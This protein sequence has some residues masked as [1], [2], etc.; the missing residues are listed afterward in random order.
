M[1]EHGAPLAGTYDSRAFRP[2]L[3]G[4]LVPP[5]TTDIIDPNLKDA[6]GYRSATAA[7][8]RTGCA[9]MCSPQPA[10]LALGLTPWF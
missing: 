2:V 10:S 7:T 8:T 5:A 3:F 9:L 6:R 1:L 4:D